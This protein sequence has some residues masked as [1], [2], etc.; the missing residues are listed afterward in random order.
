MLSWLEPI[1]EWFGMSE[2]LIP[3][4]LFLILVVLIIGLIRG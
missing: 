2:S 4:V 1:A 3:L